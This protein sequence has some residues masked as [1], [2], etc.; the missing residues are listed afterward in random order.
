M[1]RFSLPVLTDCGRGA[2]IV[3]LR[4]AKLQSF[5]VRGTRAAT[6]V[7]TAFA[8]AASAVVPTF[9]PTPA[10]ALS[11]IKDLVDIEG[12]RENQLIGYGLVIGLNGTRRLRPKIMLLLDPEKQ[13]YDDYVTVDLASERSEVA[14]RKGLPPGAFG[15]DME[16]LFL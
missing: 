5:L 12:I 7:A 14:V 13:P 8:I 3:I 15:I 2:F 4:V 6:E 1:A 10:H 16:N 11:R 9:V